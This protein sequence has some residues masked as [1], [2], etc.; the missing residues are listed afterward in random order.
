[1]N[2]PV[3]IVV[4]VVPV[5]TKK[6]SL[7]KVIILAAANLAI[8]VV[9][10]KQHAN[11]QFALRIPLGK[12]LTLPVS[13]TLILP[14]IWFRHLLPQNITLGNVSQYVAMASVWEMKLAMMLI[15]LVGMDAVRP[16]L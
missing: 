16:V 15:A 8:R 5:L 1:M 9:E 10:L 12:V 4:L 7:C 14:A 3:L 2:V 6:A 13:V 11:Q